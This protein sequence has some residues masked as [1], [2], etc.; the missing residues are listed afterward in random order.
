MPT[1]EVTIHDIAKA[2]NLSASTV[3]RALKN[4]PAIGKNTIRTVREMAEQLGY[5][6]NSMA[7][8]LRQSRTNTV[9]VI[10][11]LISRPFVAAAISGIEQVANEAGLQVLIAQTYDDYQKEVAHAQ[12]MFASRVEGLLVSLGNETLQYD[13][14]WPF[15]K[16]GV[17]VVGFDRV[18]EEMAGPRIVIDDFAAAF[19]ITRHL[20]EQGC[21]RIAHLAGSQNRE[22]Y[23]NRLRGYTE[24]LRQYDLPMDESLVLY[25]LLSQEAGWEAT[26]HLLGMSPLPDGIFSAN[27]TAAVSAIQEIQKAGLRVPANIAVAGFNNDPVATIIQPALTTVLYPAAQMGRLAMQQLLAQ[28][29]KASDAPFETIVVPTQ[30]LIRESSVR[31]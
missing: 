10:V 7:A 8:N 24:A 25:N 31:K 6:P 15:Q 23:R 17:P 29:E 11:P 30:L 3:S 14:F 16:R 12:A 27:D 9:G 20:I 1:G 13:H 19:E 18:S 26:R 21:R 2:L 28:K 5:Q 22:N 4:N